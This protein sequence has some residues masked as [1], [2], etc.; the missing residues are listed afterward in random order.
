M[1]QRVRS[2]TWRWDRLI[3]ENVAARA[4]LGSMCVLAYGMQHLRSRS[5]QNEFKKEA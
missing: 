5:T 4:A 1:T 3:S 2:G